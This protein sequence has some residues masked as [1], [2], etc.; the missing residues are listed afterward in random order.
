M[1]RICRLYLVYL[2]FR[3]LMEHLRHYDAPSTMQTGPKAEI[4]LYIYKNLHNTLS[5]GNTQHFALSTL[6]DGHTLVQLKVEYQTYRIM[7]SL[8][9]MA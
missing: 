9:C 1:V 4:I 7:W 2:H 3:A 6:C 8:R 5:T